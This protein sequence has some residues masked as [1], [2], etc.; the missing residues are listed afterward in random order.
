MSANVEPEELEAIQ[1]V[2]EQIDAV[3]GPRQVERRD[4][5]EPR[6]LSAEELKQLGRQLSETLPGAAKALAITLRKNHKLTLASLTEIMQIDSSPNSRV[7]TWCGAS[8]SDGNPPG[9]SGIRKRPHAFWVPCSAVA[10]TKTRARG[11]S[12]RRNGGCW[13]AF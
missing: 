6:R 8:S 2:V 4:F 13:S 11:T 5:N 10:T 12:V 9:W 1:D 3:M 7:P